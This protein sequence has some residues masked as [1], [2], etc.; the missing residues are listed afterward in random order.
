ME[1][2]HLT[3]SQKALLMHEK[4]K[5][6]LETVAKSKVNT[7]EDLVDRLHARRC[8]ALQGDRRK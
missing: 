2:K 6:K 1:D 3:T 5:G 4:W 7:R 8:R